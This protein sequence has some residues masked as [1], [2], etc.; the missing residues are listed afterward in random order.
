[1]TI[2][3]V[4]EFNRAAW[5]AA[6]KEKGGRGVPWHEGGELLQGAESL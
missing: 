2:D 6:A 5:T 4:S 1:M 3:V